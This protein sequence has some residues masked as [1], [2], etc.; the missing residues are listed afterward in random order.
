MK[1][2]TSYIA[3]IVVASGIIADGVPTDIIPSQG[4]KEIC[5]KEGLQGHLN[6]I[7][8]GDYSDLVNRIRF[9]E[10]YKQWIKETR[11]CSSPIKIINNKNF[12][13]IISMKQSVVPFILDEIKRKPS[14][15]V[16]ALNLIYEHKI[17][18]SPTTTITSACKMWIKFLNQ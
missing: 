13:K 14:I 11:F 4:E 7:K 5:V 2:P 12:Q 1:I 10:A 17:S 16:W 6:T 18:N 9:N 3:P 8:E 15:L